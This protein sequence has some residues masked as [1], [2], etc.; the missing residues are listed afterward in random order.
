MASNFDS[1][2]SAPELFV[3]K[4]RIARM[5][6][7][8]LRLHRP[9]PADVAVRFDRPWEGPVSAYVTAFRDA[10]RFRMYYRGWADSEGRDYTCYAESPDGITWSKP[11]L[12]LVEYRGS[13]A[14]NIM[15]AGVGVHN[16]T[17]CLDA[18]PHAAPE[19][20]YK[21][22]GRGEKNKLSLH[23][24]ASPDGLHWTPMSDE[25]VFSDGRFDSQNLAFWDPR[26]GRYRMYFRTPY[27]GVRGIGVTESDDFRNWDAPRLIALDPPTPEHFYTN[28]ITPYFRNPGYYFGFPKRF[29]PKRKKLSGHESEGISEGVFLS[30]RDGYA[31]DR[32]FM[33]AFLRPGPDPENWGDR[34]TMP[35]WGLV[36]TGDKEMSLY[37]SQHYRFP[38][39]H[40]RRGV[41]R[42]DGIASASAGYGGGELVTKPLLIEG[43]RLRLNYST[44]AGGSVRVE[45]RNRFG[46]PLPGLS[47]DDAPELY[48]DSISEEYRWRS[49]QDAGSAEGEPVELRFLLQDADLYSYRFED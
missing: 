47:L 37:Y 21:A 3:D 45:L 36:Q 5:D 18:N 8:E 24:F 16:F 49:G 40:L 22:L 2:G 48:G 42:L 13:K 11:N 23:A 29:Q 17:P 33:E 30:S 31:F 35:A 15:W 38:T 32:V 46:Q 43:R 14:N 10:D 27:E 44:G 34:S 1:I 7:V 25:P 4:R 26:I 6:G 20:R 12:G 9:Q 28:A 19:Q 39:A 41:L